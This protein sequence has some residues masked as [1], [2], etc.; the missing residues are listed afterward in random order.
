M[1]QLRE[2]RWQSTIHRA[3][4]LNTHAYFL[5][6]PAGNILFYNTGHEDDLGQMSERGGIALQLPQPPG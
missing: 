4:V 5:K 6:R 2:D 1:K 3:G